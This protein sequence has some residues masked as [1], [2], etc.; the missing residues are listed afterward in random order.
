MAESTER[1]LYDDLRAITG[2]QKSKS[3]FSLFLI[4]LHHY[5]SVKET[6]TSHN[7]KISCQE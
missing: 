2:H 7:V 3:I 6:G 1:A 4:K 5:N